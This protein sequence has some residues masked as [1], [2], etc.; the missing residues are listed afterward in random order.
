[1]GLE[2][3]VTIANTRRERRIADEDIRVIRAQVY[4]SL[5]AKAQYTRLGE[6]ATYSGL[7]ISIDNRDQYSASL[8]A[9]QL[10]YTGGSVRAALRAAESYREQAEEEVRRSQAQTTRNIAVAFYHVI[11]REAVMNVARESVEQLRKFEAEARLKY[12]ESVI[13]EF[14]WLSAKVSLANEIPLLTEAENNHD[15]ARSVLRNLLYLDND[16]WTLRHDGMV[17][18]VTADL[19]GLQEI[20]LSNRWEITQAMVNLDIL[21][22]DIQV[23][24]GEY[25][26]ELKAFASY[27]GNDPSP[28][29]LTG[30]GWDWQWTAGVRAS[31][32]L[33]DG[34][35]RGAQKIEKELKVEMAGDSIIDLKQ[36][37]KLEIETAYRN[38][39]Q[40]IRNLEGADDTIS[41]AQKALDIS[42][43]RFER[44]LSTNLEFTDRN[45]ELN[46][47]RTLR[48]SGLYAYHAALAELQYA[49]GTDQLPLKRITP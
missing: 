23:T 29:D 14:E 28:Y 1:M 18:P 47:A 26:P 43:L 4:P 32:K 40:A 30:E 42:R 21:E 49:C 39:Q 10:L 44:G 8:D 17:E 34:G 36:R 27:S 22:A 13:S 3:S 2:R 45:L 24:R 7:P 5:E 35:L 37:I 48:M 41:L 6:Q 25:F 20:G 19:G 15:I 46:R 38:L 33:L 9:E 31:W 12:E 16:A 11:Y